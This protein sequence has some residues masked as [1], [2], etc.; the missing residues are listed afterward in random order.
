MGRQYG[1]MVSQ[2]LSLVETAYFVMLLNG[3]EGTDPTLR[4]SESQNA[5]RLCGATWPFVDRSTFIGTPGTRD[6]YDALIAGVRSTIAPEIWEQAFQEG[7]SMPLERALDL[8]A[9]ELGRV[10]S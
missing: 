2:I 10:V 1:N 5:A 3:R 6:S 9:V 7:V 4:Q 8:A